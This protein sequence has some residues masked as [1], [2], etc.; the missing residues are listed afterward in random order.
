MILL[1]TSTTPPVF[2]PCDAALSAPSVAWMMASRD[3]CF[4]V[5]LIKRVH[6]RCCLQLLE[7]L[8][9]QASDLGVASCLQGVRVMKA[10][11]KAMKAMKAMKAAKNIAST[12]KLTKVAHTGNS[13]DKSHI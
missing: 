10:T 2:I 8:V 3:Q 9:R 12:K 13:C 5:G 11:K 6:C 7:F 4:R 1:I